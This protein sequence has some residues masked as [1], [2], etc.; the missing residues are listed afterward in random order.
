MTEVIVWGSY[1]LLVL[2]ILFLAF[3]LLKSSTGA[4][5]Q[6]NPNKMTTTPAISTNT[7]NKGTQIEILKDG[8]GSEVKYGDPIKCHYSAWI[9]KSE[10]NFKLVDSSYDRGLPFGFDFGLRQVIPGW[11]DGM[12]GMKIGERRRLTIPPN[13]A[14]GKKGKANVPPN[15]T[16][17]F[18]VVLLEISKT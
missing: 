6:P 15:A 10:T 9:K 1:G 14:Y 4:I 8:N 13:L 2:G 18:E 3:K 11:E 7:T 12:K 16:M 5:T 17:I